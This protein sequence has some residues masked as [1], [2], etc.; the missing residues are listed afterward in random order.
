MS[1]YRLFALAAIDRTYRKVC[2]ALK[3][4]AVRDVAAAFIGNVDRVVSAGNFPVRL[5]NLSGQF[6]HVWAR[7]QHQILGDS[8]H[9]MS[10]EEY[11]RRAPEIVA[12]CK[13]I[14]NDEQQIMGEYAPAKTFTPQWLE[15]LEGP[16]SRAQERSEGM[17]SVIEGMIA[18]TGDFLSKG[19][20]PTLSSMLVGTWTAFETLVGDLWRAA[21]NAQPTYLAVLAGAGNRIAGLTGSRAPSEM[22]SGTEE[23]EGGVDSDEGDPCEPPGDKKVSLGLMCKITRGGYNLSERMG[24]LLIEAERVKFTSL[25]AIR[26][27][28]SLAFPEKVRRARSRP[29]DTPLAL[30]DLDALSAVRNLLV[31]KAGKA[32]AEYL[33]DC[34]A[35]PTAPRLHEGDTLQL[36]GQM[37]VD[38]VNPAVKASVELLKAADSWLTATRR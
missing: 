34:K 28:Y 20:E 8:V 23:G 27:A 18:C 38:L 21:V 14:V 1:D 37:C 29:I 10:G 32:D 31:H 33:E 4:P 2:D 35:A 15:A 3:T 5:L 25:K 36:N 7:A 24:D 17:F 22:T 19:M 16:E 6:L 30:N 9:T 11:R 12:R 26:E 13:E